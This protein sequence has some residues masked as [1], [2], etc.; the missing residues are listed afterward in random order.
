MNVPVR[1][2][3]NNGVLYEPVPVVFES[4]TAIQPCLRGSHLVGTGALPL[5][6]QRTMALRSPVWEPQ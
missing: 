2:T 6:H 3:V 4:A 1:G 5:C